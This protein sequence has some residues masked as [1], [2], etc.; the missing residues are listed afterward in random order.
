MGYDDALKARETARSQGLA[1]PKTGDLS[2]QLINAAVSV[3]KA[4]GLVV[5]ARGAQVGRGPVPAQ[6]GEAGTR[7]EP[8]PTTVQQTEIALL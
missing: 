2:K 6:R 1:F 3:A 5:A 8:L 4:A 7:P